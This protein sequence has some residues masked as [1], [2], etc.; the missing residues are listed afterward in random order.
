MCVCVYVNKQKAQKKLDEQV[1]RRE[2]EVGGGDY[3]REICLNVDAET[4]QRWHRKAQKA[5]SDKFDG[6]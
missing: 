6:W 1:K 3:D 5:D 2:T 4:S